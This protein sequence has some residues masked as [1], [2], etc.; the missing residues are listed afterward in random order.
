VCVSAERL[1]SSHLMIRKEKIIKSNCHKERVRK[2]IED[3]DVLRS[4]ILFFL[5]PLTTHVI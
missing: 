3:R 4:G 5:L 2:R 1:S